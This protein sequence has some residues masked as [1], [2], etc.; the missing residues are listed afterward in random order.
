MSIVIVKAK[1]IRNGLGL[2]HTDGVQKF[3][4]APTPRIGG[5]ALFLGLLT[6]WVIAD[7]A[8]KPLLGWTLLASFPA[9]IFGL[10]E[11]IF[12]NVGASKRLLA[13]FFAG[14]LFCLLTGYSVDHLNLWWADA[15]V[16][17]AFFSIVF[18]AFA[19][20]SAANAINIIDGFHGLS[21]GTILFIL[22]AIGLVSWQVGDS[23]LFE[24]TL[25]AFSV[26][27]GFFVVNF[28]FGKIFLGDGGAYLLGFI[29]AVLTVML[30][31]RNDAVSPW[32]CPLILSYPLT[33]LVVSISRKIRR[34]GH[35]PGKPD[36]L[37]FHMLVHRAVLR[38]LPAHLKAEPIVHG[39]TSITLWILP[40]IS[41]VLV[42]LTKFEAFYAIRYTLIIFFIYL[43]F[44]TLLQF[45]DRRVGVKGTSE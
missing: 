40:A 31:E 2:D 22:G 26:V 41:L 37:H 16:S 5:V 42:S 23:L 27:A 25:I 19:I 29:V 43:V 8:L 3:H 6:S 38:R 28:P 18:T 35:H 13:S 11:D 36:N 7:G 4:A 21:S 34:K 45:E 15:V 20:A 14:I 12:R 17:I 1:F 10:V 9:F 44:Y 32:V 24:M 33:E 30:A 39:I